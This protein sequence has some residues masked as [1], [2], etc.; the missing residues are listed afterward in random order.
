[1][2]DI[3]PV[4]SSQEIVPTDPNAWNALDRLPPDRKVRARQLA[5]GI[6][7]TKL[8]TIAD[9]GMEPQ[10]ELMQ[11]LA[12]MFGGARTYEMDQ[13]TQA[14]LAE[15]FKTTKPFDVKKLLRGPVKS[16]FGLVDNLR[17]AI[18]SLE[19][20]QPKIDRL[21]AEIES[22]VRSM[23]RDV[24]ESERQ[25]EVNREYRLGLLEHIAG[26]ELKLRSL[27]DTL[28]ELKATA[29]RTHNPEDAQ[30][31]WNLRNWMDVFSQHLSGLRTGSTV[32]LNRGP[33]VRIVQVG[34]IAIARRLQTQIVVNVPILIQDLLMA[35][36]LRRQQEAL[37]TTQRIT[38]A[39]NESMRNTAEALHMGAIQVAETT[40]SDIV[41]YDAI[42]ASMATTQQTMQEM[43]GINEVGR[44][45]RE[46]RDRQLGVLEQNQVRK[47][48]QLQPAQTSQR[49]LPP[50]S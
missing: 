39:T 16:A 25:Y 41:S 31:M 33:Q 2:A 5:R 10:R 29:E 50:R 27:E 47:L 15:L 32:A 3:V 48:V 40:N 18:S 30:A 34:D 46:T 1:M 4:D 45:R 42:E 43:L 28:L 8:S 36:K 35:I 11:S 9:Y 6:D 24:D 12:P 44:K 26:G 20:V 37:G 23:L 17:G 13:K 49:A 21:I 14:L 38:D 7:H 19:K 22:Q